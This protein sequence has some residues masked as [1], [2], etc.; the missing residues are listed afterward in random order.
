MPKGSRPTFTLKAKTGRQDGEGADIFMSVGVA[1][2][3]A[4]GGGYML[5]FNA[6]PIP[7]DGVV[8]MSPIK[9]DDR[10]AE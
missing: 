9:D 4:Q 7:F 3:W 2:E 5:R 10:P 1:W 6:T 8:M